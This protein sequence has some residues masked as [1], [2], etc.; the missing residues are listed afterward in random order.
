MGLCPDCSEEG[1]TVTYVGAS[2]SDI[3][4]RVEENNNGEDARENVEAETAECDLC[5]DEYLVE[6]GTDTD[7]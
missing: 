6:E 2:K 7:E 1:E 5:G 4:N 3:V